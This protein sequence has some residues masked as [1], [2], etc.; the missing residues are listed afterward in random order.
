MLGPELRALH[1]LDKHNLRK[2]GLLLAHSG[3]A[4]CRLS[5]VAS[6]CT[7]VREQVQAVYSLPW[8]KRCAVVQKWEAA[9]GPH[10][11]SGSRDELRFLSPFY[12][13]LDPGLW[14]GATAYI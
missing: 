2:Q 12:V 1:V 10:L 8:W 3:Y 6:A 5:L 14:N 9:V 4:K 11:Q 7:L 13:V